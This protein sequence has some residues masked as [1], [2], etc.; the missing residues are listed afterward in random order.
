V[1]V[2]CA[3]SANQPL[4]VEYALSDVEQLAAGG[5]RRKRRRT[6]P[7]TSGDDTAAA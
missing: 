7:A 2:R 6:A 3:D 5:P 4:T 1:D